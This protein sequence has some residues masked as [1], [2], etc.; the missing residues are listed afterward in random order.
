MYRE[1]LDDDLLSFRSALL[2]HLH[3][4]HPLKC[5]ALFSSINYLPK[6]CILPIQVARLFERDKELAAIGSWTLVCH[7]DHASGV[8]PE[9]RHLDLVFEVLAPYRS[10]A[11]H[12]RVF[13]SI[14]WRQRRVPSL[15]HEARDQAVERRAVVS[16]RCA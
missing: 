5:A 15:D 1:L 12:N 10:T 13:W 11:F 6:D 7:R 8:M 16:A 14:G 9:S 2:V 3:S 4:L